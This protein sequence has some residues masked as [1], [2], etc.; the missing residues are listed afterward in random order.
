MRDIREMHTQFLSENLKEKD[1][2][3]HPRYRLHKRIVLKRNSDI[4]C[5][6]GD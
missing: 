2:L 3:G 6:D 1:Q 4:E 5:E